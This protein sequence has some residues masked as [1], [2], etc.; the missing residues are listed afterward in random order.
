MFAVMMIMVMPVTGIFSGAVWIVDELVK[1]IFRL[2]TA[3]ADAVGNPHTLKV[4]LCARSHPACQ[5][6]VYG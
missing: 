6:H 4:G 2:V 5:N 1:H 3:V